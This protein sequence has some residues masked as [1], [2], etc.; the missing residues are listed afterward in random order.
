[1]SDVSGNDVEI[2]VIDS[3][4]VDLEDSEENETTDATPE[5]V[6]NTV[7]YTNYFE[8]LQTMSILILACLVAIGCILG[9]VGARRE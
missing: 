9:W 6:I 4:D 1:M 5:I 2:I 8:N 7:D 3:S